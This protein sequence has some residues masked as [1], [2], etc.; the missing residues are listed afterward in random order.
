MPNNM[1]KILE[2]AGV[3][4]RSF[5]NNF[6]LE[7]YNC[8]LP[9]IIRGASEE[10]LRTCDL[11]S[12]TTMPKKIDGKVTLIPAIPILRPAPPPNAKTIAAT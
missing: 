2:F 11:I 12:K 7:F 9:D 3:P 1:W 4:M 5:S 6:E 10:T 8:T